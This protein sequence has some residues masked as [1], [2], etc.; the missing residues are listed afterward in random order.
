MKKNAACSAVLHY[1]DYAA[2]YEGN[3]ISSLKSLER[4][5]TSSDRAMLY[6]LPARAAVCAW[7]NAMQREQGNV[8]FAPK[9]GFFA[10]VRMLRRLLKEKRVGVVHVHFIRYREKLAALLAAKTCPHRVKTVC[11]LHNHLHVPRSFLGALPHRFYFAAAD[12]FVCCSESVLHGVLDSGADPDKVFLAQNAIDFA[13]LDAY[14]PSVRADLGLSDDQKLVLLF[15]FDYRRKGVDLAVEAVRELREKLPVTLAVSLSSRRD[16][17]ERAICVQLGVAAL[18]SWIV[19]LPARNDV[20]S[21]YRACDVFC[22]PSREEGFCYALIE[23]TYCLVPVVASAIDAQRDLALPQDAFCKPNDA[24][25]LAL[26]IRSALTEPRSRTA[27][28][29]ARARVEAAYSLAAWTNAVMR[30]Y[31]ALIV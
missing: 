17:V 5:L 12:A 10:L 8:Y 19:L 4:T 3:F 25:D 9:S 14:T 26:H 29:N 22:S 23:A 20:A 27:L 30:V 18:P 21:Y 31:D 11:H 28:D 1:A 7:A 16:E 2:P 24:S 15:G 13:R 6:L